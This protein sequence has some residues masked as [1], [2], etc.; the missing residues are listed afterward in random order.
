MALSATITVP[1]LL[2]FGSAKLAPN[3]NKG[4]TYAS[5]ECSCYKEN[6]GFHCARLQVWEKEAHEFDDIRRASQVHPD[7]GGTQA[8][9]HSKSYLVTNALTHFWPRLLATSLAWVCNGRPWEGCGVRGFGGGVIS[10]G[11]SGRRGVT[12]RI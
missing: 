2:N 4:K 9:P 10:A 8:A 6:T 3:A 12:C 7:Q 1:Q 5:F 11:W